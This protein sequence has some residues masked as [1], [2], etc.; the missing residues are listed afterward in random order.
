MRIILQRMWDGRCVV[1]KQW[2]D[3]DAEWWAKA[4][5]TYQWHV[6]IDSIEV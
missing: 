2:G 5:E 3:V 4:A 1:L 6:D